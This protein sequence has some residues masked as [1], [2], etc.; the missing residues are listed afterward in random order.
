MYRETLLEQ[1]KNLYSDFDNEFELLQRN[2]AAPE[3]FDRWYEARVHR[4]C[5]ITYSEGI[6][7]EEMNRPEF[8]DELLNV[9]RSFRF[10]PVN[11]AGE[12]PVRTGIAAGAA[13][14]IA[15]WG[16]LTLLH[17]GAARALISGITICA[18]TV[19]AVFR[20]NAA[21]RKEEQIRVRKAYV[22]QLKDYQ[23]ALTDVCDHYRIL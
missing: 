9:M 4:W 21:F 8:A 11:P 23:Q 6:L 12:R 17:W 20:S 19:S 3:C 10:H 22:E 1:W 5:S 2:G 13:A 16:I 7:L 15:V 14:G 18:V